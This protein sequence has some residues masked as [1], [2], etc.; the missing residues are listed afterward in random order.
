[1]MIESISNKIELHN[2]YKMP[3]LGLGV[4]KADNGE[5]INKAIKAALET[6]YRLIDTATFYGNEKGVGE[7]I[8]KSSIP[9]EEIFITSKLWIEDQ[10]IETTRKAFEE[11]LERM[12]LEYLDLYLIHWPKPGKYLE[13]WKVLQELYQEGK[14]R[15]IGV[16]NCMIHHLESIK[17]LGGVQPMV[18]Q[19][20]FHPKLIQQNILDY[21]KKN[22]IQYQAWSPLMRGEILENELIGTI[23][24]KYGKSEAQIVIRW[25]LQKRVVTIPKSV[26]KQRIQENADVFDFELTDDEVAEIDGLEDNTR[27]GAHPDTFMEEMDL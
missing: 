16:C 20:E 23:A 25:D 14:I 12:E 4:Y 26:H 8:R 11:T 22:K 7:A 2:G 6:G 19:N 13:S 27:T 9:R 5:E 18:L 3:G 1:M 21:C 10:G 24:E 17:E 15:A